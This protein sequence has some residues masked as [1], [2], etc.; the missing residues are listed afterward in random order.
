MV[1]VSE[2]SEVSEVIEAHVV[3]PM[4]PPK[5]DVGSSRQAS[6]QSLPS[7]NIPLTHVLRYSFLGHYDAVAFG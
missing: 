3:V 6:I 5:P 1:E 2:V 4:F 7:C